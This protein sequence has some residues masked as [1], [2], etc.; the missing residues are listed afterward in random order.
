LAKDN[1]LPANI[2]A[3]ADESHAAA[4]SVAYAANRPRTAFAA[5]AKLPDD[6]YVKASTAI[7]EQR[8][9]L[10]GYRLADLLRRIFAE[11]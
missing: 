2:Q 7:A 10:A 6:A 8:L 3:W 1:A 5:N 9:T 11:R 4:V